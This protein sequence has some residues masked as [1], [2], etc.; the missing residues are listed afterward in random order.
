MQASLN[1][2]KRL[3]IVAL[4]LLAGGC[5]LMRHITIQS[6][7]HSPFT[8]VKQNTVVPADNKIAL[9]FHVP[10]SDRQDSGGK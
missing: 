5:E 8:E 6:D 4:M 1:A 3:V 2:G 7:E 10:L 9:E